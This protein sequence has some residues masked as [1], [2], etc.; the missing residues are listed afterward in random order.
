VHYR[1]T[2]VQKK[3]VAVAQFK[4]PNE[5]FPRVRDSV[6]FEEVIFATIAAKL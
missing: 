6:D 3:I 2:N 5:T 1:E 4:Q